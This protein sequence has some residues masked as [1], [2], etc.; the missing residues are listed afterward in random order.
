MRVTNNPDK[1]VEGIVMYVSEAI[2]QLLNTENH[3]NAAII[4]TCKGHT[5]IILN[6]RGYYYFINSAS[7]NPL[8]ATLE[9]HDHLDSLIESLLKTW[10]KA[11][12]EIDLTLTSL[13]SNIALERVAAYDFA[14]DLTLPLP[15]I[16]NSHPLP[17]AASAAAESTPI[18]SAV[19]PR[20]GAAAGIDKE[21]KIDND[22]SRK[23]RR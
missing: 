16:R 3:P 5:T 22:P 6:L 9:I 15:N 21:D 8:K 18:N 20:A 19:E 11:A 13:K 23:F 7:K 1:L 10:K 17:S 4:V 14:A 2:I 12:D